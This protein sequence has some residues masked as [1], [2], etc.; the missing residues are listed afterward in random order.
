MAT[1]PLSKSLATNSAEEIRAQLWSEKKLP[2]DPVTI[3]TKLGIKVKEADLAD[4]ISGAI[5][6]EKNK[7]AI[8]VLNEKDSNNR[9]RFT[10]AHELGHYIYNQAYNEYNDEFESVDF[11]DENSKQ[12]T[13]PVEVFANQFAA[14]LLMPFDLV[15]KYKDK[16]VNSVVLAVKFGVSVE[17]MNH[18][19]NSI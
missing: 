8:I 4:N 12:G 18:R 16:G 1:L 15:K 11:R 19:L 14:N 10:C 9:K 6:K 7:D 13:D 17:A 2:I 5:I 3:A